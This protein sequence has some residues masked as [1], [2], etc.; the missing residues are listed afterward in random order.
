[1][2]RKRRLTK[3]W[4]LD[5]DENVCTMMKISPSMVRSPSVG[6]VHIVDGPCVLCFLMNE[7]G[8]GVSQVAVVL[9]TEQMTM[10]GLYRNPLRF[11]R[12]CEC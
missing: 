2:Q 11:V 6:P 7:Y 4:G 9:P 12:V 1:M 5:V 10:C 8:V 3:C